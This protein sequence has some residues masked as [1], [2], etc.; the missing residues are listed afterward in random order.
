VPKKS[1]RSN[2]TR[3][4]TLRYGFLAADLLRAYIC[5]YVHFQVWVHRIGSFDRIALTDLQAQREGKGEAVQ[6]DGQRGPLPLGHAF[7]GEHWR[8]T[9]RYDGKQKLMTLGRYP[10]VLLVRARERQTA[11]RHV[12]AEGLDPMAHGKAS[13]TAERIASENSFARITEQWMEHWKDGK[14]VRHVDSTQRRLVPNS[15]HG[16]RCRVP[17]HAICRVAHVRVLVVEVKRDS[18]RGQ[19]LS[20]DR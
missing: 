8:S 16:D 5:G 2:K 11:E 1:K 13:K 9:Y 14:T 3:A 12:L 17:I 15:D 4:F 19:P 18:C 7:G 10:N 20:D 6:D